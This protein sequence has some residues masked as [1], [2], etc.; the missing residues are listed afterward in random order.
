MTP[1]VKSRHLAFE[2]IV[3]S[4]LDGESERIAAM[5]AH[6]SACEP[7]SREMREARGII[8]AVSSP[9]QEVP[10]LWVVR[11]RTEIRRRREE[12]PSGM[13][14]RLKGRVGVL[15]LGAGLGV[16]LILA[17]AFGGEPVSSVW[18]LTVLLGSSVAAAVVEDR[19]ALD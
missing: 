5:E 12:Q 18:A 15:G 13:W 6:A 10:D 2:E 3:D 7:C 4:L 17:A 16:T 9:A 1:E 11:A 19:V 8:L 14:E